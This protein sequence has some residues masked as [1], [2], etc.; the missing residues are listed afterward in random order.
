MTETAA[1]QATALADAVI[2][3][4]PP[5]SSSPYPAPRTGCT[6]F[7]LDPWTAG[8]DPAD[9]PRDDHRADPG[10]VSA[11]IGQKLSPDHVKTLHGRRSGTRAPGRRTRL[12]AGGGFG[13]VP[14]GAEVVGLDCGERVDECGD[15]VV[16]T[17]LPP[18]RWSH[19]IPAPASTACRRTGSL[20]GRSQPGA[21]LG[22]SSIELPGGLAWLG[23][24]GCLCSGGP[25]I[26]V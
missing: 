22:R 26:E 25:R 17:R 6:A 7:N 16:G 12:C 13:C 15:R 3:P 20:G 11:R 23:I 14:G 18:T 9:P 4:P 21:T 19:S 1:A 10:R 8:S 5:K 2:N 24:C